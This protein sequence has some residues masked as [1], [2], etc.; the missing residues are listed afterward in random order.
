MKMEEHKSTM[1]QQGG[2]WIV[3]SWSEQHQSYYLSQP[4]SYQRARQ[5]VATDNCRAKKCTN[6]NHYHAS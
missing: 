1:Y 4:M 5:A 2:Q 6:P 3:S